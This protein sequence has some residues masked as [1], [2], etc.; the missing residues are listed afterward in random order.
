LSREL[1]PGM[2]VTI[3][4]GYYSVPA[5][6]NGELGKKFEPYLDRE[7]LK[8]YEDVRGIRIEDVVL[9]TEDGHENLSKDLPT[10]SDE[11]VKL[12]GGRQTAGV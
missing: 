1:E 5:L 6:L 9:V 4:P 3:E 7:V 11:I 12:V 2:V 10:A 8:K